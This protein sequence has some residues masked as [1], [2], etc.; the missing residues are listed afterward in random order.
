MTSANSFFDLGLNSYSLI[1][2]AEHLGN[3]CDSSCHVPLTPALGGFQVGDHPWD[4]GVEDRLAL[5]HV[6]VGPEDGVPGSAAA[7]ASDL[8]RLGP[9]LRNLCSALRFLCHGGLLE[10]VEASAASTATGGDF[11]GARSRAQVATITTR[12]AQ[13]SNIVSPILCSMVNGKPAT[14]SVVV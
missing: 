4:A 3:G 1:G 8:D 13:P 6:R 9:D 5:L 14:A 11:E 12:S 2:L 7:T 10:G